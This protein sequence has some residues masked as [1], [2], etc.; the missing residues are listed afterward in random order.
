MKTKLK[1]SG[2][3][4]IEMVIVIAAAALMTMLSVPAMR[5]LFGSMGASPEAAK[6]T[7]VSALSSARAIA[8]REQSYAGIRFQQDLNGDQYMIFIVN[9]LINI[10]KYTRV[11]FN[12]NRG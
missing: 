8:A 9:I 10:T 2:L 1:Q 7:I 3:S 4:L 12:N 5:P 11:S 6:V